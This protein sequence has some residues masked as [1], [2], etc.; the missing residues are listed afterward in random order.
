METRIALFQKK[1]IRKTLH[2]DTWWFVIVDVVGTVGYLEWNG[3]ALTDAFTIT[4]APERIG[5]PDYGS[6]GASC[7]IE[8]ELDST[9]LQQDL[10]GFQQQ[11]HRA[12]T[13][14][15]QAVN[16]Q[17]AQRLAAPAGAGGAPLLS[18]YPATP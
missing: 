14:A 9:L 8:C 13:A 1:E 5:L 3:A 6:L 16:D 12:Y 11:V 15:W 17:L 18:R 10:D 7:S 4:D 2:A